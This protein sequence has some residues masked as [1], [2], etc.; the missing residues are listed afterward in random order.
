M[1]LMDPDVGA[2]GGGGAAGAAG[3]GAGAGAGASGAGAAGAGGA[4]GKGGVGA[5]GAVG[6]GAAGQG[7]P[8]P[9]EEK[10]HEWEEVE[11]GKPV[12]RKASLTAMTT[13]FRREQSMNQKIQSLFEKEK[14]LSEREQRVER[15]MELRKQGKVRELLGSEYKGNR[16]EALAIALKEE[17]DEERQMADPTQRAL[18][19][20]AS[21]NDRL[22]SENE[23][24]RQRD[25]ATKT[26]AEVK[27]IA[28][29]RT[30]LYSESLTKHAIPGNELTVGLMA[31]AH[32]QANG[33]GLKLSPEQ[34]AHSTKGLI[35]ETLEGVTKNMT[36]AQALE[37]FPSFARLVHQG[38]IERSRGRVG[39]TEAEQ[40]KPKEKR[41]GAESKKEEPSS[42]P[43]NNAQ[44][45][46][47]TG[48]M[49]I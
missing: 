15:E 2:G 35:F 6:A 26:E 16:A 22:R 27:R 32:R 31:R 14:T 23:A 29:E 20:R 34:L 33:L 21:E 40:L 13:A 48:F 3:G 11:N 18:L 49:G 37:A 28:D 8:P 44:I 9:P 17:L 36:P 47:R 25:V 5:G 4:A 7:A 45:A 43:M 46:K 39:K 1:K 12:K 10:F 19:E 38:L 42:A 24:F 30:A 41:E